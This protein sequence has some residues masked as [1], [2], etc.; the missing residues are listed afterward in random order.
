VL[1]DQLAATSGAACHV[2]G[3]TLIS[4]VLEA[5]DVPL[6]YAAGTLRLSVG[7]HTTQRDVDT[8]VSLILKEIASQGL[9]VRLPSLTP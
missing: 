3:H 6:E 9:P 4:S 7:R 2:P 5:M 1:A 8:A